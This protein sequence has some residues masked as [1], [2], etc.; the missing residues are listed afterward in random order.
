MYKFEY[1]KAITKKI[2]KKLDVNVVFLIIR[3][4]YKNGLHLATI[5]KYHILNLCPFQKSLKTFEKLMSSSQKALLF[6]HP[7]LLLTGSKQ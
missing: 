2:L 4:N 5:S 3:D 1:F 7:F 6:K